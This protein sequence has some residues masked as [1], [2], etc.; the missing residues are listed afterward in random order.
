MD[1]VLKEGEK[2]ARKC[3]IT[4]EGMN[5]G[6]CFGDGEVYIKND[7]ELAL[8]E[9]KK[10]GYDSLNEAYE[11]EAYYFTTWED[12]SDYQ[13]IVKDGKLIDIED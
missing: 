7:D 9:V 2:W 6:F 10:M 3:D 13:Y 4:G 12:E 1:Q 5:E 8:A 11:D